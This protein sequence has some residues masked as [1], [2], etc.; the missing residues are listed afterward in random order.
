MDNQKTYQA[1]TRSFL[2]MKAN[3]INKEKLYPSAISLERNLG[4]FFIDP[5]YLKQNWREE[6]WDYC[7][8]ILHNYNFW[9]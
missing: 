7:L 2:Y 9:L 8:D 6:F 1:F 4:I 5:L 3:C